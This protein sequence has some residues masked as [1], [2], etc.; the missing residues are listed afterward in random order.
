MTTTTE[1]KTR[2]VTLSNRAPVKIREDEWP[3][4]ASSS[5]C[6]NPQIPVQANR[7]AWLKVRQ[8]DDG[9]TLVYGGTESSWQGERDLRSGVLLD[10]GSDIAAAIYHVADDLG[11]VD[12]LAA[13]AVGDLPAEEL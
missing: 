7:R 13:E 3:V 2:I 11:H 5:W 4:I 1:T 12:D 9:R 8:H 6:D 10:K